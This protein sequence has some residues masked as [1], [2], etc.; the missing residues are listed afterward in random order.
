MTFSGNVNGAGDHCSGYLR[1]ACLARLPKS[2]RRFSPGEEGAT[3]IKPA[4]NESI[5]SD[6]TH[7]LTH[8]TTHIASSRH[9]AES[10]SQGTDL[11][12]RCL[13]DFVTP[14]SIS[15]L[16]VYCFSLSPNYTSISSWK[17]NEG[18][19]DQKGNL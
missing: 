17:F 1:R 16:N 8:T 14:R 19:T 11:N 9:K 4:G 3:R 10:R 12:G 13:V 6:V 7:R 15:N 18:K 5:L 2:R